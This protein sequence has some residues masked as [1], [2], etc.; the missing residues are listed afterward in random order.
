ME[1]LVIHTVWPIRR[2]EGEVR[3]F[4]IVSL[5]PHKEN[6]LFLQKTAGGHCTRLGLFP[7][8]FPYRVSVLL[9]YRVCSK[10]SG[11]NMELDRCSQ[12]GS[13]ES[14]ASSPRGLGSAGLP[15]AS[16]D[17]LTADTG[18]YQRTLIFSRVT[19]VEADRSA[20]LDACT[21]SPRIVSVGYAI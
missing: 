7:I 14:P 4:H 10:M 16:T 15:A 5:T 13:V 12:Q 17:N 18:K 3:R 6:I 1:L 11:S 19:R 9:H 21:G 2:H 20:P 8:I